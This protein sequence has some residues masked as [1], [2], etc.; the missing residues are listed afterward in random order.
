MRKRY[1]Y[2]VDTIRDS[3]EEKALTLL[4]S[5]SLITSSLVVV[6]LAPRLGRFPL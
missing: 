3:N 1:G 4:L 5:S 2:Y 6:Y